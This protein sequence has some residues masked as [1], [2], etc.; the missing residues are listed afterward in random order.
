MMGNPVNTVDVIAG[1]GGYWIPAF[2]GITQGDV[3]N[4]FSYSL[5]MPRLSRLR[6]EADQRAAVSRNPSA[7]EGPG[8]Q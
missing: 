2:A 3:S 8:I 5:V 6:A 1:G 4:A 7:G